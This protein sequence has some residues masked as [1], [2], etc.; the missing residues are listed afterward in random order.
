MIISS[1]IMTVTKRTKQKIDTR[2][3]DRPRFFV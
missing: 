2:G 1:E 3:L